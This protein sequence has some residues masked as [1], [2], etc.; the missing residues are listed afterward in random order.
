MNNPA[1]FSCIII[2]IALISINLHAWQN[3]Y[4]PA[5]RQ[6]TVDASLFKTFPIKEQIA[7]RLNIDLFNAFNMPG[8]SSGVGSNGVVST[9]TSANNSRELQLTLRLTW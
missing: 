4:L 7:L 6:W 1:K 9:R 5:P 2:L 8:T 3:Q